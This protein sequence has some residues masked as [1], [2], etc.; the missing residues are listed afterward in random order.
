MVEGPYD[1]PSLGRCVLLTGG[2]GSGKSTTL[3]EIERALTLARPDVFL[4]VVPL[5]AAPGAAAVADPH[6]AL[7]AALARKAKRSRGRAADSGPM[8]AHEAFAAARSLDDLAWGFDSPVLLLLDDVDRP[9]S[10]G[11]AAVRFD[12]MLTQAL[13]AHPAL[14]IVAAC[15]REIPIPPEALSDGRDAVT[16]RLQPLSL[17]KMYW[18]ADRDDVREKLALAA[19]TPLYESLR[20]PF[21]LRCWLETVEHDV[22]PAEVPWNLVDRSLRL[23]LGRTGLDGAEIEAVKLRLETKALGGVDRSAPDPTVDPARKAGIL[24]ADGEFRHKHARNFFAA[25]GL[26]ALVKQREIDV[27]S[28]VART[29]SDLFD[30]AGVVGLVAQQIDARDLPAMA[31]ALEHERAGLSVAW[32]GGAIV[33]S[34]ELMERLRTVARERRAL[35]AAGDLEPADA[36]RTADALGAFDTVIPAPTDGPP[37]VAVVDPPTAA[38]AEYPVTNAEFARFIEKGGYRRPELWNNA[39]AFR[40]LC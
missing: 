20:I 29:Q 22:A 17:D 38:L 28:A 14:R 18:I 16:V 2:T 19:G 10:D 32:L 5:R 30:R 33:R 21:L 3:Q 26:A 6:A 36:L 11:Q 9:A 8:P 7:T 31:E 35:L 40:V 25:C 13:R 4:N 34:P 1:I 39:E 12:E 15:A 23:R 27:A 37:C 24:D